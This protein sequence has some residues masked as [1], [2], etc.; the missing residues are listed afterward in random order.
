MPYNTGD[1]LLGKYLV[2]AFVGQG[3][4]GEVYRVIHPPLKP[5]AIKVLRKDMPGVG[6]ADI[7]KTRERFVLEA[8]L[9]DQLSHTNVIKV[10]EFEGD[11]N[12]LYLVMEYAPGGSLK[13]RLQ[14][15]PFTVEEAVRLGVDVCAGLQAIHETLHAVHRD[16]KPSN[17]LFA[18]DGTA[19]ICDLGLA[20]V[21]GEGRSV[22]GS[23]SPNHPGD[24]RYKSPEQAS[25]TDYLQ[26]TS[27]IFSLGC[28]LFEAL[29]DKLYKDYYG[30]RVRDYRS[31]VPGWLDEIIARALAEQPGRVPSAD[32]DKTK[33]YRQ[34]RIMQ[35]D[36][37]LG[38]Q[39]EVERQGAAKLAEQEVEAKA[40]R[41]REAQ[42]LAHKIAADKAVREKEK[43]QQEAQRKLEK[44][45]KDKQRRLKRELFFA[46]V[47]GKLCLF[48]TT[49][50]RHS[51]AVLF[52]LIAIAGVVYFVW[53]MPKPSVV[54]T[55][56]T[57][58]ISTQ[59]PISTFTGLPPSETPQPSST[60]TASPSNETSQ[61]SSTP[62]AS[63]E[64]P[65]FKA[66]SQIRIGGWNFNPPYS[67]AVG[68]DTSNISLSEDGSLVAYSL[69]KVV[70]LIHGSNGK[71]A[72]IGQSSST[73]TCLNLSSDGNLLA[74]A[75]NGGIRAIN[76]KN[77]SRI[78][79]LNNSSEN[80]PLAFSPDS[81]LLLSSS[82]QGLDI[83]LVSDGTL[84]KT[85]EGS[86]NS[87][88]SDISVA[89]SPNGKLLGVAS[90]SRLYVFNVKDWTL[91]H[92]FPMGSRSFLFS[93]N[94]D[95][96]VTS[97]LPGISIWRVSDWSLI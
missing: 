33:R 18:E 95:L 45:K 67:Y 8:R 77:N 24:P 50:R 64:I 94:G 57:A 71:I 47:L 51:L 93:P 29:T 41:E 46:N 68:F 78:M 43:A 54:A 31:D 55:S 88:G 35:N 28:V 2:E 19:R 42:E 69:G 17:I 63:L 70:Y 80:C 72:E 73:I 87:N 38:W 6:S 27:D 21:G 13:E 3:S 40:A 91:S 84:V 44:L 97:D 11:Q 96:L 49:I 66:L 12:E 60:F 36:L 32:A 22:L 75:S 16:I 20:Q 86:V 37:Q 65:Q 39:K 9:G 82:N 61:S 56:T 1:L 59:L 4:F 34:A 58:I 53:Y 85:L 30:A 79:V 14:H 81:S 23:L 25:T 26:P 89:F 52:S 7:Q 74:Y 10:L 48:F 62:T 15:G 90:N 83:R 5:R 76:L 92:S